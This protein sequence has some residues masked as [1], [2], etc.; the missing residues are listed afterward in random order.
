MTVTG[1]DVPLDFGRGRNAVLAVGPSGIRAGM[2]GVFEPKPR[3]GYRA[4]PEWP[5][6]ATA[7]VNGSGDPR[8]GAVYGV[9][10]VKGAA[11]AQ[12]AGVADG[13]EVA[14]GAAVA[15]GAEVG[16]VERS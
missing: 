7:E 13:A 2:S 16:A 5:V 15:K 4:V 9:D 12:G 11:V 10:A 14:K 6:C 8:P 1:V 3:C